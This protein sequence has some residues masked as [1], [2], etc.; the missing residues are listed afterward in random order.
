MLNLRTLSLGLFL[1]QGL[2]TQTVSL[3]QTK[4]TRA[5]RCH[6]ILEDSIVDFYVPDNLNP[7]GGYF[8]RLDEAGKFVGGDDRF[9]TFQARQVWFFSHLAVN[10]IR[11]E[12]TSN[13]AS[14]GQEFLRKVHF[15]KTHG[16]YRLKVDAEGQPSDDRNHVYPLSFV[17]YGLCER[18]RV[19]KAREPLEHALALFQE[20]EEHCYD[21]S[22]GGYYELFTSDWRKIDDRSQ[23]GV[24]GE[25]GNKTY[26]THLHLLEAFTE[27]W[28]V[29]KD[30]RVAKRLR[31]LIQIC[32][33]RVRHPAYGCNVDAWTVD[34]KMASSPEIRHSYGHDLECAWLVLHA[35][36]ALQERNRELE[37]WAVAI[38]DQA[39]RF[40]HDTEHGGF[41]YT[42]P[43]GMPSD[44]RK[45]DWW[46]QSEALVGLLTCYQIS[47]D[48]RYLRLFDQTLDFIETHHVAEEGGWYASLNP[49]GSK[50]D[51]VSRS[52]QWQAAY[53][54]GRALLRCEKLLRTLDL[55]QQ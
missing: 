33:Q 17:I 32:T 46:T 44:D 9:L 15:D 52:S 36:D 35:A 34:W 53:H 12:V 29:S 11:A 5:E 2:L 24:V 23:W 51:H 48:E 1:L 39:I 3:G 40:G 13:I 8:Q 26:N 21:E 6:R 22:Y 49:D 45:K 10:G 30:E 55:S 27:L 54:N 43:L 25:V 7:R 37:S 31:E 47:R 20:L 16:G 42:G 41:F 38:C 28:L 19:D 50:P 4:E 14:H 18:H